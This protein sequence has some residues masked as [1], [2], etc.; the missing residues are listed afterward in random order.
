MSRAFAPWLIGQVFKTWDA[1]AW[2][3]GQ[4]V[5][6]SAIP[7]RT[8]SLLRGRSTAAL[9][10]IG[11]PPTAGKSAYVE[12]WMWTDN[13]T[14]FDWNLVSVAGFFVGKTATSSLQ[15]APHTHTVNLVDTLDL[16]R[17]L[18]SD[19]TWNAMPWHLALRNILTSCA[20]IPAAGIEFDESLTTGSTY[21]LGAV[22]PITVSGRETAQNVVKRLLD[23]AGAAIYVEASGF[24]RIAPMAAIPGSTSQIIYAEKPQLLYDSYEL[25]IFDA[26]ISIEGDEGITKRYTATGPTRPDGAIPNGTYAMEMA[27]GVAVSVQFPY[28]QSNDTCLAIATREMTKLARNRQNVS[29]DAP[30]NPTLMPGDTI[31]FRCPR[32]NYPTNTPMVVMEV[33]TTADAG[34]KV[35][36]SGGASLIDGYGSS[37]KPPV[38]DFGVM[39]ETE[40]VLVSGVSTQMYF[41]ACRDNSRETN[42]GTLVTWSWEATHPTGGTQTSTAQ[43]P[44]FAFAVWDDTLTISLTVTSDNGQSATTTRVPARD[45]AYTR[46]LSVALLTEWKVQATNRLWKSFTLPQVLNGSGTLVDQTAT[47][48]PP[49]CAGNYLYM[50]TDRGRVYRTRDMLATAPTEL[51]PLNNGTD[52]SR[53]VTALC[54][55][56]MN[57]AFL[58]A[59]TNGDEGGY[60]WTIVYVSENSGATWREAYRDGSYAAILDCHSRPDYAKEIHHC[61]ENRVEKVLLDWSYYIS[62][63]DG[64]RHP[65]AAV[66]GLITGATGTVARKLAYAYTDTVAVFSKTGIAT[67]DVVKSATGYIFDW[68]GVTGGDLPANGLHSITALS[69]EQGYVMGEGYSLV[70]DPLLGGLTYS[71]GQ[72]KVYKALMTDG[73]YVVSKISASPGVPP[74]KIL[75][76]TTAYPVLAY[77]GASTALSIGMGILSAHPRTPII[78]FPT[79]GIAHA[80]GGGIWMYARGQWLSVNAPVDS[81]YWSFVAVNPANHDE[82][83]LIGDSARNSFGRC[84]VPY[85][86]T[87]M[88]SDGTHSAYWHTTD[89]GATWVSETLTLPTITATSIRIQGVGWGTS[90]GHWIVATSISATPA[91]DRPIVWRNGVLVADG[92]APYHG[93]CGRACTGNDG[94]IVI[95]GATGLITITRAGAWSQVVAA[96]YATESTIPSGSPDTRRVF[97]PN[98][99]YVYETTDYRT[100]APAQDFNLTNYL[101]LVAGANRTFIGVRTRTTPDTTSEIVATAYGDYEAVQWPYGTMHITGTLAANESRTA[102]AAN[103][104]NYT[105]GGSLLFYDNGTWSVVPYPTG[106]SNFS[107]AADGYECIPAMTEMPL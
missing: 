102:F 34:M 52:W 11:T 106:L 36:I 45:S 4:P 31:L 93:R 79:R 9:N 88:M 69:N 22:Y 28:A 107:L 61:V 21:T 51:L 54:A 57:T 26:S 75:N 17:E 49:M 38:A 44:T 47:C 83:I 5:E 1:K 41:I 91:N 81:A 101:S 99:S 27:V 64:I 25:G 97:W 20:G 46:V 18:G 90:G 42:G 85:A 7:T 30:L 15:A 87:L 65:I 71:A 43:N 55:N 66:S 6:L 78:I 74:S 48:I 59:A 62:H 56:E 104:A 76:E 37:T 100:I 29:F 50:G 82:W 96:G 60:T 63:P 12:I 40:N 35:A 70:N 95:A 77:T 10:I 14:G 72:G 24:V 32:I 39:A 98:A 8:M 58:I 16:N 53:S 105:Y 23:F 67:A 94:D 84:E 103:C 33:A 92:G 73:V 13:G 86:A 19:V 80:A 89:A 2:I 3:D 68:S